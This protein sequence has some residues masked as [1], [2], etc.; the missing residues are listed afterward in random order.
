MVHG[1]QPCLMTPEGNIDPVGSTLRPRASD[2]TSPGTDQENG[3]TA[4]R[5]KWWKGQ[6][7]DMEEVLR[8]GYANVRYMYELIN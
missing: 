2:V 1:F 5:A 4:K 6:R 7:A 8:N 3:W